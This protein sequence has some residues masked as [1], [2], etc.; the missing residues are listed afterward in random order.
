MPIVVGTLNI[1]GEDDQTT[2]SAVDIDANGQ[3]VLITYVD[4]SGNLKVKGT[5]IT[6]NVDGS[7]PVPMS[8]CSITP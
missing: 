7:L 3:T 1:P 5:S 4:S 8:G 6:Q 2:V